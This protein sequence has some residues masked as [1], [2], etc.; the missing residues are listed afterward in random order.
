MGHIKADG[1]SPVSFDYPQ[2]KIKITIHGLI[3]S[4]YGF[5]NLWF[6]L[7]NNGKLLDQPKETFASCFLYFNVL[8]F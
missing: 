2:N 8:V 6:P 7:D 1:Q 4:H 3:P 5:L